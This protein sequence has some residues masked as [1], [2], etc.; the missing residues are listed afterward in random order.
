MKPD[1]TPAIKIFFFGVDNKNEGVFHLKSLT[2]KFVFIRTNR[3]QSSSIPRESFLLVFSVILFKN[4]YCNVGIVAETRGA[5]PHTHVT[6][7]SR[8][9]LNSS[10]ERL[11][12]LLEATR[13]RS[14]EL[15]L[16]SLLNFLGLKK[17]ICGPF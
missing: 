1:L 9:S 8:A 5:S 10:A 3:E 6:A 16:S 14:G 4:Y 7:R 2:L 13:K 11:I 17:I 12:R 15:C